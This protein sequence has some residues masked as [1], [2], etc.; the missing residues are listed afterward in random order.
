MVVLGL[1]FGHDAAASVIADGRVLS[2][3]S[4]ERESRVKHALG[5]T[6]HEF[7]L[8]LSRADV[9]WQDVDCVAVVS[10]QNVEVLT[11]L[12]DG[13]AVHFQKHPKDQAPSPLVEM[14]SMR[15]G[16]VSQRLSYQLRDLF[17]QPRPGS[18]PYE[19]Y[20]NVCQE[21]ALIASGTLDCVGW[22]DDFISLPGWDTGASLA[23]IA[24]ADVTNLLALATWKQGFHYPVTVEFSGRSVPGYFVSHHVAHGAGSFFRSGAQRAAIV[25]HDG[26]SHGA[27][28][29][30]GLILYG[31]GNEIT[32]LTPH[33]LVAAA[34]YDRVG[35]ELGLGHMGQA[36]KLMGLAP[37]GQPVFF[38]SSFVGNSFDVEARY[39]SPHYDAWRRH[40]LADATRRG[41][42]FHALG[43]PRRATD[44]INA[45]YAAST[46]LLFENC[47]LAVVRAAGRLFD[48]N[49][50]GRDTL[51]LSG[52]AA[53]NCPSNSRIFKEGGF[54]RVFVE[55]T[56]GDDGLAVGAALYAFHHLHGGR[57]PA[58]ATPAAE[59]AY[60]GAPV[61][62]HAVHAALDANKGAVCAQPA[63]D[64]AARAARDLHENLIV[65]W[66]EGR[67][68][69][70]P[71]ALGHRSILANPCFASNWG[72]VNALKGREAWRPFAPSVLADQATQWFSGLQL[73]SPYMLFTGEVNG[74]RIPAVTHVDGTARVQTVSPDAGDFYRVLQEFALLSGVP[75]VLNTSLNGPGE[76]IV[77]TPAQSIA[78]LLATELDA[79]YIG[80]YR[81]TRAPGQ[82]G[83]A[84]QFP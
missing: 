76:P 75:I 24:C 34:L 9:D 29:Q 83:A 20:S 22:L 23:E 36:G 15:S 81:V 12:I 4:R 8:A 70:G 61:E 33:H 2:Y 73:D 7:N 5:L 56:C 80:G 42:D 32:P 39:S 71:R 84:D 44:R 53:L 51:C 79:L 1:H 27:G 41:Y 82:R 66:V 59:L 37:Y 58:L 26:F 43:D 69:A 60:L 50:L 64:A 13:F 45:D 25:T 18:F 10:T 48:R 11:G 3:V 65:A 52:G 16:D 46:Q 47:Y 28:G 54:A 19:F 31:S 72:R 35:L 74:D 55:P 14:M 40:V 30:S 62:L 77:E 17:S 6:T 78:F 67:S 68:E 49:G 63:P 38:E 57:R 21:Q